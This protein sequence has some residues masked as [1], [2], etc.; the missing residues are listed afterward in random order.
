MVVAGIGSALKFLR[1][2]SINTLSVK[3]ISKR[4]TW[5]CVIARGAHRALNYCKAVFSAA[6]RLVIDQ[7]KRNSKCGHNRDGAV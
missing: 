5:R 4:V 7:A 2:S 6:K 1:L 3:S